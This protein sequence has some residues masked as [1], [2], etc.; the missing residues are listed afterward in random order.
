MS[1]THATKPLPAPFMAAAGRVLSVLRS[2]EKSG[3]AWKPVVPNAWRAASMAE[4]S[5]PPG[6]VSHAATML[7]VVSIPTA[8]CEAG[9][10]FI[11]TGFSHATAWAIP[12][13]TARNTMSVLAA[14]RG[15]VIRSMKRLLLGRSMPS[16][17]ASPV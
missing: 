3:S 1:C 10:R 11:G 8:G 2:L 12:G 14:T 15:R 4:W 5:A 17:P 6:S 7:P 9:A 16:G 13:A